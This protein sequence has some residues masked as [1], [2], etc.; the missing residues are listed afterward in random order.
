[1]SRQKTYNN[2]F[3]SADAKLCEAFFDKLSRCSDRLQRLF[4]VFRRNVEEGLYPAA[5]GVLQ[6]ERTIGAHPFEKIRFRK[7]ELQNSVWY[8]K[9]QKVKSR[10][11][12]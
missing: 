8:N 5:H 4:S 2:A 9:S 3:A 11:E 10:R 6:R 1:M 7:I 12:P